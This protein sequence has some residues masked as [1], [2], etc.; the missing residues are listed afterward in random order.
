M[1]DP[2]PGKDHAILRAL[3]RLKKELGEGAFHVVEQPES[4]AHAVS[5]RSPKHE[6]LLAYVSTF[7][8]PEGFYFLSLESPPPPGSERSYAPAG[9]FEH[10]SLGRL[11]RLV[12]RH[13]KGEPGRGAERQ[14][15]PE[16]APAKSGGKPDR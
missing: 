3:D 15:A 4:S 16:S 9:E 1:I 8:K 2:P 6:G 14:A 12:K 7:D 13:L 11:V 5:V 10:V